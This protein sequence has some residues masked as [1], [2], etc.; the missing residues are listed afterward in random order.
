MTINK[1]KD[2]E[3]NIEHSKQTG[4][5]YVIE[6]II[7]LIVQALINECNDSDTSNSSIHLTIAD[8]ISLIIAEQ[9]LLQERSNSYRHKALEKLDS[10]S[11]N[12]CY[13]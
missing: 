10:L 6:N 8:S 5:S 3:K 2:K 1:L 12:L 7:L 11:N 9:I 13:Y 4:L